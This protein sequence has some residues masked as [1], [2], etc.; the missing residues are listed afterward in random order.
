MLVQI[1]TFVHGA[2]LLLFGVTVTAA[3]SGIRLTKRNVLIFTGFYL[4]SGSLQ[5]AVYLLLPQELVWKLY[6]VITHL[7]LLLLLRLVYRK[8]TIAAAAATF[9]A[10][11]GC[12]PAKWFGV[13]TDTF[14]QS[15]AVEYIVRMAVLLFVG[16]VAVWYLSP[17]LS[18]IFSKDR[19]SVC[20]FGIVPVVYYAFDY[21]T[22]VYT[23]LWLSNDRVVMEFLPF[24]LAVV[25]MVFCVVYY[26]EYEQKADALRKENIIRIMAEQQA[27]EITAVKQSEQEIRLLRH[28]MRMLLSALAIS[29]ENGEINKAQEMIAANVARIEGTRLERFCNIETLNYVLSDYAAK[30]REHSIPFQFDVKLDHIQADE[31]LF[32]SILSNALDNAVNAQKLLTTDRRNIRLMLKYS[33]GKLL[34][35]VKNPVGQPVAFADGLPLSSKRG[36]GY[37]AQSIRYMTER[38]GGN[39]QFSVQNDMFVLRV[40]L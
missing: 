16:C 35:S 8:P 10:Y 38:L 5:I 28:D 9:S 40:V 15:T 30:C 24:F 1:L 19:R 33:G 27:K 29:I 13:L 18:E 3:F 2:V 14:I 4:F 17:C 21:A 36:H 22:V 37:G 25:Y 39:C 12:Q 32:C 26:K 34:L 23:N 11:L 7:P 6:P 20:I 31:I